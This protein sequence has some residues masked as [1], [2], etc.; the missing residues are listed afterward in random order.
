MPDFITDDSFEIAKTKNYI[1]SIQVSLDG[2]SFLVAD[3]VEKKIVGLK[4]SLLKISSD[5]LLSRRLKEWLDSEELLKNHFN[6]VRVLIYTD[7]FSLIPEDYFE[8]EKQ[9]NL[10]QVLFDKKPGFSFIENRIEH[11][12]TTLFFPVSQDLLSV[13]NQFFSKG[14]EVIHP[15]YSL[16]ETKIKTKKRNLSIILST[17]NYFYLVV[18]VNN[19]L[20]LANSFQTL[21]IN[22]LVY[23]VLN[24]FQQLEVARYETDLF[25]A[26]AI[27]QNTE[28]VNLL[29]PYFD[30]IDL[31]KTEDLIGNPT[32]FESS[33]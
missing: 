25:V 4:N 9:R 7:N 17:K 5:K 18:F 32:V 31:I 24:T 33:N 3:P 2:F 6:L 22:D 8:R 28:I 15:I 21:H 20:I 19:Q 13:L 14:F 27:N 10:S 11:L 23:N 16:I 30:K 12:N 26:G 1:L 29:K